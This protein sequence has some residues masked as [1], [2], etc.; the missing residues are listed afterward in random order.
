MSLINDAG[1]LEAEI[2][3]L[4]KSL[5]NSRASYQSLQK[6]YQEQCGTL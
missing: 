3:K 2:A 4:Q 6:Q 1:Q 5:D